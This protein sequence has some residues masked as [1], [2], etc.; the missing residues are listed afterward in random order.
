MRLPQPVEDPRAPRG[1]PPVA[2]VEPLNDRLVL[3]YADYRVPHEVLPTRRERTVI[4]GWLME[5]R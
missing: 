5:D 1:V 3:F 2:D 4:V